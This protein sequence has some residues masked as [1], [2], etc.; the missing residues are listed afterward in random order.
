MKKTKKL[1]PKII[2][3]GDV[4]RIKNRQAHK[5]PVFDILP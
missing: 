2:R 3:R 1:D 4:V 5:R